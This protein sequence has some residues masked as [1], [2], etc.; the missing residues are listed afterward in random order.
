MTPAVRMMLEGIYESLGGNSS[1]IT[2][3]FGSGGST[4]HFARLAKELYAIESS[5]GFYQDVRNVIR[6]NV[7]LVLREKD[8]EHNAGDIMLL[9]QH[10][11][12][13]AMTRIVHPQQKTDSYASYL[14]Q[15]GRFRRRRFDFV[16]IDGMVRAQAALAVLDHIDSRSRVAIHDFFAQGSKLPQG[17]LE[18]WMPCELLKSYRVEGAFN[19]MMPYQ[20]GGSV[21]VLQKLHNRSRL[22]P[23]RSQLSTRA[24]SESAREMGDILDA[25]IRQHSGCAALP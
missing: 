24:S 13:H 1:V 23:G 8:V 20:S 21:V 7:E 11:R 17:S 19:S 15:V 9:H 16:L 3:E 5:R 22:F 18:Y 14:L 10:P 2:L 6:P 4:R 12:Y 25:A